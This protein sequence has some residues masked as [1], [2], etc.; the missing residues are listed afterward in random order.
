MA[1]CGRVDVLPASSDASPTLLTAGAFEGCG[2]RNSTPMVYIG[3]SQAG[4]GEPKVALS[5]AKRGCQTVQVPVLNAEVPETNHN[6]VP[7][8]LI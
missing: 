4:L 3:S 2:S 1:S 5:R 7:F 6:I 8:T